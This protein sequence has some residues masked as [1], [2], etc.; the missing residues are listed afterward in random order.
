MPVPRTECTWESK[1]DDEFYYLLKCLSARL[2]I[3]FSPQEL[4]ELPGDVEE[5]KEEEKSA[6]NCC[7]YEIFAFNVWDGLCDTNTI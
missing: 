5:P 4:N 6:A 7:N 3:H 2:N 1:I